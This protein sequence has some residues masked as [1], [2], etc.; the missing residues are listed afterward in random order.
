[1]RELAVAT[2][3]L[4][5]SHWMYWQYFWY[6]VNRHTYVA[7]LLNY[8]AVMQK[9]SLL[10]MTFLMITAMRTRYQHACMAPDQLCIV[11]IMPWLP[12][13]SPIM[14]VVVQQLSGHFCIIIEL[15]LNFR[16]DDRYLVFVCIYHTENSR[17][18]LFSGA[19]RNDYFI[20]LMC[21]LQFVARTWRPLSAHSVLLSVSYLAP[22]H[23]S[24]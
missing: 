22:L 16:S 24:K 7:P 20:L 6:T 19:P 13:W 21:R 14:Y 10:A 5:V 18:T 9:T 1:M 17:Y 3:Y 12:Q 11:S 23:G 15:L 8:E 2:N 4:L